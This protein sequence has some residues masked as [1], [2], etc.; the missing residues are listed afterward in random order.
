LIKK[1]SFVA[2]ALP[3]Q[4]V[5]RSGR[6]P[7][8][9]PI[10]LI[11][12][13]LTGKIF[14]EETKTV[15]L[16]LH[17]A[18]LL[19]QH[20][21]SP[22]Q[23]MVLR[24]PE[25]NKEAEIRIVGQIGEDSGVYTYGAAFFDHVENFWE[26]EFPPPTPKEQEFGVLTLVCSVCQTF[27]RLDDHSIEA[28]VVATN[29]GVLRY[30]KRCGNSTV[31]KVG[32]PGA[33]PAVPSNAVA[34]PTP[35]QTLIP[36]TMAPPQRVSSPPTLPPAFNHPSQPPFQGAP[37]PGSGASAYSAA[38]PSDLIVGGI[39]THAAPASI[40]SPFRPTKP[41]TPTSPGSSQFPTTSVL[42]MPATAE[43]PTQKPSSSGDRHKQK[44]GFSGINRRKYPR[45]K[46]NYMG[47]VRHPERGEEF[48]QCEDIS[49]GGLRFKSTSRYMEQTL[50]EVAAP[51][52]SGQAA[53]FVPARIVY[54]QELPEQNLF[55]YGVQ[56]LSS[57]KPRRAF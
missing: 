9:I 10:V 42:T 38:S 24:W 31:W 55:R 7:K 30:C 1:K 53:I 15:L 33:R 46:V 50:I 44:A 16:S 34:R 54:V 18:G 48:V 49:R 17:G 43:K 3:Q 22:E 5:R 41:Y 2:T 25:R 39:P 23:E 14:S 11:G 56:Y 52:S 20:K 35:S 57:D 19:S 4:V 47:L 45:I 6:I 29:D 26:M 37:Q 40:T 32:K 8:E 51:Y 21:L 13:D 27:E 36:V 12:S 28:D